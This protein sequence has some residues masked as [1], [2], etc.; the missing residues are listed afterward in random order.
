[1]FLQ[2]HLLATPILCVDRQNSFTQG[3]CTLKVSKGP[4]KSVSWDLFGP[5]IRPWMVSMSDRNWH[6]SADLCMDGRLGIKLRV[7]NS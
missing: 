4:C 7:G 5:Q 1:M 6:R 3:P 2:E